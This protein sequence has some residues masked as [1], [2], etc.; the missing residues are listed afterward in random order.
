LHFF[1]FFSAAARR[2]LMISQMP[3]PTPAH[4]ST[5]ATTM[6]TMVHVESGWTILMTL[7]T[8]GM[9]RRH[10]ACCGVVSG[11]NSGCIV[12]TTG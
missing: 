2:D 3:T 4:S 1:G 11:W 8:L 12:S 9:K 6:S 7:G 10:P 5:H